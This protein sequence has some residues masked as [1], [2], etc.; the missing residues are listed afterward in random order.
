MPTRLA[1]SSPAP[2]TNMK[3]IFE[4]KLNPDHT[5]EEY[6]AAW[7]RGSEVIQK[8]PGAR[9]TKLHRKINDPSTVLAIAEWDSKEARDKAMVVLESS[10]EKTKE[11]IH[12]HREF[13]EFVKI[14]EYDDTDW[15]VI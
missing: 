6:A 8:M 10:D 11:I 15:E 3:Y 4:V 12:E 2:S 1:G 14:G 9:G 13:G 7:K 5:I